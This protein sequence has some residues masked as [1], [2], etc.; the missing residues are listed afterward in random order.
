MALSSA[1]SRVHTGSN[2]FAV[3]GRAMTPDRIRK[4]IH[5]PM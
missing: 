1:D 5:R 3:R 2:G 4:T